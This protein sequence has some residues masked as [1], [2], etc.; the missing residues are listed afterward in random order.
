MSNLDRKL[1]ASG[2]GA[3]V[4]PDEIAV[5]GTPLACIL[6]TGLEGWASAGEGH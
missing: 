4:R 2:D 6:A 5:G 3:E 1:F